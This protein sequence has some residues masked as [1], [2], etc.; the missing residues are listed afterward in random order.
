MCMGCSRSKW[1]V[2]MLG[3]GSRGSSDDE[4]PLMFPMCLV[5]DFFVNVIV[6]Y[7]DSGLMT[8]E[9]EVGGFMDE[10]RR[11]FSSGVRANWQFQL[12]WPNLPHLVHSRFR[13]S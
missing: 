5:F 9:G 6:F 7:S 4:Y 3:R 13:L 12:A 2:S 10:V 11:E 8:R 1:G